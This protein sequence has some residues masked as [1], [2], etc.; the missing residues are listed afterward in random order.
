MAPDARRAHGR[1]QHTIRTLPLINCYLTDTMIEQRSFEVGERVRIIGHWEFA[2]GITGTIS[3]PLPAMI[4]LSGPGEWKDHR[5]THRSRTGLIVSYF[6]LF[7][8]P[9]DD[10][11]GDCP[12]RGG[13]IESS[14]L[15]SISD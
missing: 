15:E 6:D 4:E 10:G 1:Q 8:E 13:E 2:D 14:C 7:D 9:A 12:Y 5:R 3:E 11:P